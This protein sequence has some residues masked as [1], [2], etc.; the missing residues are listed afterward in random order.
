MAS[1]VT[2]RTDDA[3]VPETVAAAVGGQVVVDLAVL[4]QVDPGAV[5]AIGRWQQ[6]RAAVMVAQQVRGLMD[7]HSRQLEDRCAVHKG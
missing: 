5:V 2:R 4:G 6:F 1:A 3:S 7:P